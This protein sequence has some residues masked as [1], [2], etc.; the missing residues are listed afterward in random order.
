MLKPML[1]LIRNRGRGSKA[2]A[3]LDRPNL[4]TRL[5][6]STRGYA[7]LGASVSVAAVVVVSLLTWLSGFVDNAIGR[8]TEV[9]ERV[10]PGVL[11]QVDDQLAT[12]IGA[13]EG[14]TVQG[15]VLRSAREGLAAAMG[16]TIPRAGT[17]REDITNVNRSTSATSNPPASSGPTSS[18]KEP[19]AATSIPG[20]VS[21]TTNESSPN[22]TGETPSQRPSETPS[23]ASASEEPSL[24]TQEEPPSQEPSSQE[25]PAQ[26]PPPQEP[27]PKEE[28][29]IPEVTP[30]PVT[31]EPPP[32]VE[33]PSG[34][35]PPP[36]TEVPLPVTKTPPP[37]AGE[38][39]PVADQPP[40]TPNGV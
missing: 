22:T 26:E 24:T 14:R 19:S 6:R 30:P 40:P 33:S 34:E 13:D 36:V 38:L 20:G 5:V 2:P 18:P 28:T 23:P 1:K 15:A 3:V 37:A 35:I 29:P 11:E 27:S 7:F 17:P 21:P 31:K 9:I 10:L 12:L 8:P 39:P 32:T 25:P 4:F 16:S